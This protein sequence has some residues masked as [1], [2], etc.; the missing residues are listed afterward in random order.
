MSGYGLLDDPYAWRSNMDAKPPRRDL[1]APGPETTAHD[2]LRDK[3]YGALGGKPENA[4]AA[5]K[6]GTV[7]AFSPLGLATG[8]YDGGQELA[9]T[10]QPGALAMAL[11][12]GTKPVGAAA[13]AATKVGAQANQIFYHGSDQVFDKFDLNARKP[14][15]LNDFLPK[16]RD[17]DLGIHLT[18]DRAIAETYGKNVRGYRVDGNVMPVGSK[19]DAFPN[20]IGPRDMERLRREG[21]SAVFAKKENEMIAL[22]PGRIIPADTAGGAVKE[23]TQ[24]IRAYHGS[25]HDFDKFDL[26]KIRTGN[27]YSAFGEGVNLS[28]TE[29]GA[30]PYG[31]NMY[32]VQVNAPPETFL[33]WDA[34][35]SQQSAQVQAAMKS[36]LKDRYTADMTGQ[37]AAVRSGPFAELRDRLSGVGVSGVTHDMLGGRGHVVFDDSQIEILRKYG[38]LPPAVL[39]AGS[40]M[41]DPAGQPQDLMQ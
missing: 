29:K 3:I 37:G 14:G 35:M 12:P 19:W 17:Y 6:L 26:A 36:L 9:R 33:D 7:A 34:E 31:K 20:G 25:P 16:V 32:E 10:A 28:T 41:G 2:W 5:D 11:M 13:K 39:G 40:M 27:G 23:A 15:I 30:R 22:D 21:Y 24:G 4:W 8:A 38:L 1:L 18:P